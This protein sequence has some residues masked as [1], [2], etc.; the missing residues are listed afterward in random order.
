MAFSPETADIV[1]VGDSARDLLVVPGGRPA[2]ETDCQNDTNNVDH[3][4]GYQELNGEARWGLGGKDREL[5]SRKPDYVTSL[6]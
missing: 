1:E 5:E 4:R 2:A 3:V 6:E